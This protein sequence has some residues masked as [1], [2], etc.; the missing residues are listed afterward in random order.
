M[1]NKAKDPFTPNESESEF[2]FDFCHL[3]FDF[4]YFYSH[5]LLGVN[6]SL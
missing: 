2:F 5:F 1:L 6:R 3:L 4:F